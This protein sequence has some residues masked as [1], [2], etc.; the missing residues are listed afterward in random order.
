MSKLDEIRAQLL[1]KE[2]SSNPQNN[3]TGNNEVYPFWNIPEGK[4]ATIRFLD[5]GNP[6]N[7][8]FWVERQ[9]IKLP[10]DG[11]KGGEKKE[12]VVQVPC[13]EMWGPKGSC[14]VLAE[15]RPWFKD[16]DLESMGRKYWV[17]RSYLFQGFVVNDP[18]GEDSKPENPVR[19]FVI[20]KSIFEI[21]KASLMNTEIEESPTDMVAGR[22]FKI[23]KT[24][25]GQYA[26]YST[27]QWSMNP[28]ALA[29]E[30]LEAINNPEF[31][32]K[33]LTNFLPKQPDQAHLDAI[34]EMFQASVNGDEYDLDKW[35]QYYRP[36]GLDR[37]ENSS[38]ISTTVK[39]AVVE[40]AA[41]PVVEAVAETVTDT[42]AP[43]S[44]S[45]K[46]KEQVASES[47]DVEAASSD[48]A[49]GK[50]DPKAIIEMLR[51]RNAAT[52]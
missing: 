1:A 30:E 18:M 8:F 40:P 49:E 13:N 22:D 9:I 15:V 27:S 25:R 19:R 46:L 41:T 24:K 5:D 43:S 12:I 47:V 16:P 38:T 28:R 17:K 20:N 14:P 52:G 44:A 37:P 31:A 42:P 50:P 7:T 51:K 34:S 39:S 29:D 4:T 45:A 21:I 26:D 3:R 11:V 23:N 6:D 32:P 33:D 35:G 10:F 2:Q 36:Y 48:D